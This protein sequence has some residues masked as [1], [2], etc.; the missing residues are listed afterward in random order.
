MFHTTLHFRPFSLSLSQISPQK[1]PQTTQPFLSTHQPP[2]QISHLP[3]SLPRLTMDNIEQ[4]AMKGISGGSG[5]DQ[6]GG[7]GGQSGGG[8]DKTIDQGVYLIYILPLPLLPFPSLPFSLS[9][10]ITQFQSHPYVPIRSQADLSCLQASTKLRAKRG[11]PVWRTALLIRRS[12]LRLGSSL[13][14]IGW[15]GGT[16]YVWILLVGGD[17]TRVFVELGACVCF[18]HTYRQP[19]IR[20]I[21]GR[22]MESKAN[23][24][25]PQLEAIRRICR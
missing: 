21:C 24:M 14:G 2:S 20:L 7:G 6:Q 10:P 15:W 3:T 8:M 19:D 18:L 22:G 13:E 25:L 17:T 11:Y 16:K 23:K 1:L 4:D 12:I 5:G 9:N